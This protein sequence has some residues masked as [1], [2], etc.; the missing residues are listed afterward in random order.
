MFQSGG[1]RV[2]KF[3]FKLRVGV[4]S[5][6]L[7]LVFVRV[8]RFHGRKQQDL[9][10]NNFYT[11]CKLPLQETNLNVVVISQKHR[12][13]VDSHSPTSSWWQPILQGSA[14]VFIDQLSLIISCGFIAGLLFKPL[15]LYNWIVQF[16]VRVAHFFFHDKELKALG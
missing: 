11:L 6:F 7:F 13:P 15:P 1:C 16:C 12:Q 10:Q 4:D 14:E 3:E 8:I 2:A 9:L 5:W